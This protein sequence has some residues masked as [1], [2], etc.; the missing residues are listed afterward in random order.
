[1]LRKYELIVIFNPTA[2]E[3][4]VKDEIKRIEKVLEPHKVQNFKIDHW[5][6]K[7]IAYLVEKQSFGIFVAIN[8]E[9]ASF[10]AANALTAHCRLTDVIMKYQA[11]R[12]SDRKRKFQGNPK[13]KP[14]VMQAGEDDFGDSMGNDF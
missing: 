4:V 8:F 5:G 12:I 1:M 9:T 6:R 13:R 3:T 10:E 11:H 2:T 14:S 7:Q